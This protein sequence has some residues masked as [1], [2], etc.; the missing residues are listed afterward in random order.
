MMDFLTR[1]FR[2]GT[3]AAVAAAFAASLGMCPAVAQTRT[4]TT[5]PASQVII[6]PV[7]QASVPTPRQNMIP[8]P[9]PVTRP[10]EGDSTTRING[11]YRSRMPAPQMPNQ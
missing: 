9:A 4:T 10:G 8:P 5:P 2:L 6:V 1:G 3:A 7:P 11:D